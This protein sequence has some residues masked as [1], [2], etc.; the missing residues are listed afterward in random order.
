M[1]SL[2]AGSAPGRPARPVPPTATYRLQLRPEF[3]FAAAERAVPHLAGL[4]I[5]HLHLSPVL[6]AVPG[7][8]HGY[9]VTDHRSV[10]AELG[11]EPGLRALAATARAH[12]L[13]LVVDLVP[14]HMAASPRHN[15]ALRALLRDGPDSPYARW[16]D[17]DRSAGDGRVLLPV[18]PARLPEVRDR[19]RVSGGAL[20]LDGQEFPL[21]PGT[22]GLPLDALLDAQWYR[23]AWW[24]LA[25]TELNYRRFFTVSE[26]I[27]VRVE[28]PEV[29]A[30]THAKIVELVGDGVVA[31][32]RIDHPDGLADPQGYL[33]ALAAATG[34]RCWTVVEKILTG[35]ERLPAAWPVAGTTGYDALHRLDGV[36]TDRAGAGELADLYREFTAWPEDGGGRWGPTARRAAHEV[37]G[38][39]LAAETAVL[40][41]TAERICAADPALRDHAPWALRTAVHE[42]LVR[43]PVYRPYRTGDEEALPPAAVRAAKAAFTVPE[44][45]TAV[46]VVRDLA[47]GLLGDGPEHRAFRA[48]FA[49]TSSALRAKSSEDTAFY[50]YAPLL[51]ANEVGGD[52]GRPAVSPDEFHTYCLR[53]SRD[54]P[55]TGTVLSTHD[56][57]RSAEVRAGIAVL[58]Q[59]PRAWAELLSGV[60]G[61]PA[62]DPHVAWTGWQTAFG[63]GAPDRDRLAP[64]LLKA[65][66]EAGLR[67]GWT[68]P[69]AEYERAVDAF[70]AAGP[71]RVPLRGASD[72]ALAL[73]PHIQAHVLGALLVQ[74]TM[75]GVPELYQNT[76]RAYRALV[77]PDNRGLF[78]PGPDDDRTALVRAAL[79]LRRERPAVF[80]AVGS[81]APLTAEGPAARHCL[82]FARSGRVVTAVTRLPLRLA[83][84]GGWQDTGLTLPPGRWTDALGGVREFTGGPATPVKLAQLFGQR[85]VALLARLETPS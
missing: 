71:G 63:F 82:A 9:D 40:T 79:R 23:L 62:P 85:P 70:V 20:R 3:P 74:L 5:S 21:R 76:E 31:G 27:G 48:R 52:P 68:E 37:A 44:E 81:Y 78:E 35:A 30:A 84:A 43:V 83:E 34:G 33:E 80:S 45:A 38:H 13:G 29:F 12:G 22:E 14:N 53:I 56:T 28:D 65:V 25:R 7:S 77:D 58:S 69:D 41:R 60:A 59:C 51:S 1:T 17:V 66:R 61:V 10:R 19:L 15:H 36:F 67:T 2:P 18:L 47:L 64:A 4:G 57:K 54:W 39:D 24:R 72:A 55:D 11:G 46:D 73:E 75:P 6:E 49:Q 16:F 32:L 26:L 50:R 42:L 8:A